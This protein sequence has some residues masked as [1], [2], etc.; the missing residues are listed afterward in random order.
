MCYEFLSA[1]N[2]P[3][4]AYF[5][6]NR[7]LS[8]QRAIVPSCRCSFHN[9]TKSSHLIIIII[10]NIIILYIIINIY[11]PSF[12]LSTIDKVKRHDGT[13]ARL[14]RFVKRRVKL[15]HVKDDRYCFPDNIF[16]VRQFNRESR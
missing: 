6:A 14:L 11:I 15:H 10:Y 13:L 9:R 1:K 2:T 7:L 5:H 12:H 8:C 3:N 16:R 4:T